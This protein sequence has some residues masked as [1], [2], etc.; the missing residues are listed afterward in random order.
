MKQTTITGSDGADGSNEGGS[1]GSGGAGIAA[2]SSTQTTV[3][4]GSNVIGGKGGDSTEGDGGNGGVGITGGNTVVDNGGNVTGGNGGNS[5][6][7]PGE[8]GS[9]GTRDGKNG[10]DGKQHAHSW[11]Y[12]ANGNQITAYCA[13]TSGAQYCYHQSREHALKLTLNASD[14]I[15]SDKVYD[16][17]KAVTAE[18]DAASLHVPKIRYVGTGSTIYEDSDAAP[19][20]AGTYEASITA[21]D[22]TATAAFTIQPKSIAATDVITKIDQT[23]FEYTGNEITPN[24]TVKDNTRSAALV[25]G[26]DYE[27]SGDISKKEVCT[28]EAY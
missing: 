6:V 2:G 10:E 16:G 26:T 12:T 21:G 15:Y 11:V 23:S 22:Q 3:G 5:P 24:I 7:K 9:A 1:G 14:A 25:A 8:G 19:V 17:A 18:W 27:L 13:Q 28:G 4:T 20:N